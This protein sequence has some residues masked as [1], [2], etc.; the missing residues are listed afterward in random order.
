MKWL[1]LYLKL[2]VLAGFL[3]PLSAAAQQNS[4]WLR[5]LSEGMGE[6]VN[7]YNDLNPE[8]AA[9]GN[10]VHTAWLTWIGTNK[11]LNYRRSTNNGLTWNSKIT[12]LDNDIDYDNRYRRMAV[13]GNYV[14]LIASRN[15]GTIRELVYFRSS[16][17]GASFE[18]PEV[19]YSTSYSIYNLHIDAQGNKVRIFMTEDCHFCV[20]NK[21]LYLLKSD[22][23][24]ANF[25][26]KLIKEDANGTFSDFTGLTIAGQNLYL[27][28]LE[29]I[30]YWANYD[31]ELHLLSSPDGG[32]NFIDQVIS[33]P[34]MSGQHHAFP[35]HDSNNGYNPKIA[36]DGN[37]VWAVW[38]GWDETNTPTV[39]VR[40]SPDAGA[41][42]T[43]LQKVSGSITYLHSGLETIAAKGDLVYVIFNTGNNKL[44]VNQ[45]ADAGATFGEPLDFTPSSGYHL[46]SGI[47]PQLLF[48]PTD[49]GAF[50]LSTGPKVGKLLPDGLHREANFYGLYSFTN[51]RRPRMALSGDFLHVLMEGGGEWTQ[52]GVF[53]DPNIWYR[54]ISLAENTPGQDE[55]ALEMA[56]IPNPGDG[57]GINRFDNMIV[58]PNLGDHFKEA[59]TIEFWVKPGA[60]GVERKLLTQYVAGTWNLYNPLGFQ[61]WAG[62]SGE[63]VAGI[64]TSTGA[65]AL[66]ATKNLAPGFWN[67]LAVTYANDGSPGNF[68]I[69]LNGQ[70]VNQLTATGELTQQDALWILGS[71]T[72][73]FGGGAWSGFEGSF[74][75]LRCWSIARSPED[76]R[77]GR[78]TSLNGDEPGLAAYYRFNAVSPFGEIADLSGNGHTGH[79]M[80]QEVS[81]PSS[82]ADLGLRFGYAQ[83]VNTFAFQQESEGAESFEWDFGNGQTS[84]FVNPSFTY[85]LPG[86]YDVCLTAYG[87][88]MFDTYC[89]EV[90][91]H[92][93]ERIFPT[94]GGN[95]DYLTLYVYGGGFNQNSVVKLRRNGFDDIVALQTIFD[96]GKTLTALFDLAQQE[97]GLWDLVIDDGGLQMI[98]P[99]A[100]SIVPGESSAPFVTYNGGGRILYNRWTPQTVT[101]GNK[102]N[103]DAHGV[104]LWVTIPEAPG[105]DIAFLNLHVLP[106]QVAIDHGHAAE[107]EALGPYVV[108][109]SLFGKPNHAR[110]YTF[111]FPILPARSSFDIALRVKMGATSSQV[112]V[113]V[114]LSG[115]FYHSPLSPEV[116]G[117]VALSAAKALVKAGASI[118]PGVACLTGAM[119][120]ASDYLND[121]PPTPSTFDN[122]DTRSW[123]WILG[124]NLL[125]CAASLYGGSVITGMLTIITSGVEAAQENADCYSGFRQVGW[126]DILYYP[127]GS[128][129]PNEKAGTPG[130]TDEG[131]IG[132][133]SKLGYQVRFENKSTATAPAQEVV[134]LDT[135]TF[136]KLDFENF[137]FGPFGWGDT[138]LFPLPHSKEFAMDVDLRPEKDVIVRVVGELDEAE[139]LVKWRFLS[140]DPATLDLVWDPD[141]GFLPPNVNSPEGEGFVNFTLG[142]SDDILNEEKIENRATIVFDANDPIVTDLHLNTFDLVAP[143]SELSTP[144]ATTTDTLITLDLTA[145]DDGSQVRQVEIW[146]SEND[147]AYVFSHQAYGSQ[148]TFAGRF[149]STYRFYSIA[150]DSVGNREEPPSSPDAVVSVLTGTDEA[151]RLE[152]LRIYPQ[153]ATNFL[154]LELELP[155]PARIRAELEDLLGRYQGSLLNAQL[156]N[157]FHRFYLPLDV[158]QG[159]Y[160][161]RIWNGEQSKSLKIVVYR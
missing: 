23:N 64:M 41:S 110:V 56:V 77:D 102:A 26:T 161:L 53:T 115:P 131:Y 97:V 30:G 124:S 125:E 36:A 62:A 151:F 149:G 6:P 130:Y 66:P 33:E 107:L 81:T 28:Y 95:T 119:A 113:N 93:I 16:D 128:F 152:S 3:L 118:I 2:A 7:G 111:Y 35:L 91:V 69:L 72:G 90:E 73:G 144:A 22:D 123:G 153:P 14:H 5:N 83:V 147:S 150:V 4:N 84:E 156:N 92:G 46:D 43:P 55:L 15:L 18:T 25:E 49:N 94:E 57:S 99:Q 106:P 11:Q 45:S 27:L 141:G 127:V 104:V 148:T 109:D 47:E 100:F 24:G 67:H 59:M 117:C 21:W 52:T 1:K 79:L 61:L 112:P 42:F 60:P 51:S 133:Q 12:L 87:G 105:N 137:S 142:L 71:I 157:G 9:N 10:M 39:F 85:A 8:I 63:P 82:I 159:V 29:S 13:S 129:D 44:Y 40:H 31:F 122:L 101:I 86:I 155:A 75:E 103:V 74:D 76:I 19:L 121:E 17:G 138:I 136:H 154:T 50:A 96:A 88:E 108:V 38:S 132:R 140:L 135:L 120:V 134:I 98:L 145:S 37:R 126:L 58:D 78:F 160:L 34:A 89:E 114:W 70:V 54:R 80:Y 143:A 158:P 68:K 48:D 139:K 20:P 116:Q 65:Y 32:E 146:A